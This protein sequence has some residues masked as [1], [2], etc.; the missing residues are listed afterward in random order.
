[1]SRLLA[2][3]PAVFALFTVVVMGGA[4]YLTGQ[5]VAGTWRPPWQAVL[6]ALL[7]GAADRF[8]VFALFGGSLLSVRGYL[9]DTAVILALTMAAYRLTLARR[10]VRQ[11]PWLYERAGLFRWRRRG[12]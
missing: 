7:L 5:A 3:D 1:V 12:G 6:Y 2:G 10:M 11:Y 4:G 9:V 8:L